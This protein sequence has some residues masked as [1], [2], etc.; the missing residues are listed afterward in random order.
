MTFTF[1]MHA[2]SNSAADIRAWKR[3]LA[4]VEDFLARRGHEPLTERLGI[5]KRR[6]Y[7]E[8]QLA[9]VSSPA[10]LDQLRGTIGCAPLAEI[11][12]LR[13]AAVG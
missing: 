13:S 10:Y 9:R 1:W 2:L 12:L 11:G 3:H 6:D 7:A 5:A 8:R 4:T